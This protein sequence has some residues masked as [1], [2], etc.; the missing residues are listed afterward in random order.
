[1]TPGHLPQDDRAARAL[2]SRV[3]EPCDRRML[4]LLDA[5]R[6][7]HEAALAALATSRDERFQPLQGRL[8]DADLA[9]DLD[10]AERC[11]ARLV[12][13]GDAEWP[14]GLDD[15]GRLAPACVWV[16]GPVPL[17][18]AL[19][20]SVALVGSRA[21]TA[22][23]EHV[24]HELAAGLVA[25]A[26]CVVS[27]AAF[28]I[29]AAAHRGALG[30]DGTTV[31]VLAGGVD[32][33]YPAA[34]ARLLEL[35]AET[36]AV[37]SEVPPACAPTRSRFLQR[38]RLIAALTAGTVVIE[39]GH[40][41]GALST[42]RHAV[43]LGRPVGA[44]PGPVT[45]AASAGCHQAIRDGAALLVT[46]AAEVAELC[47]RMGEDLAPELRG[48]ECE[49]DRLAPVDQALLDALPYARGRALESVAR[50]AGLPL[51]DARAAFGRLVSL[52]LAETDEGLCRLSGRVRSERLRETRR[53]R[54]LA[55]TRAADGEVGAPRL[56]P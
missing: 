31:A 54:E 12:V 32:R 38:N 37:V 56:D 7:E 30:C 53:R 33:P 29:D 16:R 48:P 1:M 27:G 55:E 11:G 25:R 13:P 5:C 44:V 39:A 14:S 46:D 18:L 8:R 28:G 35:V 15:L 41:S 49:R 26:F 36:G 6:G 24:A 47:G 20:R 52:D 2:W 3:A 22:Y 4:A 23:G 10:L 51:A 42:V 9:R 40:R 21:A 34:H 43:S 19:R 50:R 45:S 17:H